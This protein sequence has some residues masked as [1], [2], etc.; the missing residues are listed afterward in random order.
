MGRRRKQ[1]CHNCEWHVQG[2]SCQSCSWNSR[3][4]PPLSAKASTLRTGCCWTL[5]F[6]PGLGSYGVAGD[7]FG[8]VAWLKPVVVPCPPQT[9]RM[10]PRVCTF[11]AGNMALRGSC[12]VWQQPQQHHNQECIGMTLTGHTLPRMLKPQTLFTRSMH[13]SRTTA[14]TR[15]ETFVLSQ[16]Y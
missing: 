6:M 7:V 2:N 11:N 1:H 16:S 13:T 3:C 10:K 14:T 5:M 8:T 4:V 9:E 12:T 15:S